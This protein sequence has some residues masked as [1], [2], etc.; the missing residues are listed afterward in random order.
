MRKLFKI[1]VVIITFQLL[2]IV[3]NHNT[4]GSELHKNKPQLTSSHFYNF[5]SDYDEFSR[6]ESRFERFLSFWNVTGAS[7]AF[8]KD[9]KLIYAKGFGQSNR[10]DNHPVEPYHLFRIASVSKLVTGTAIMKLVEDGKLNLDDCVFGA[11][12]LLNMAPY[13]AY[14]DKKVEEITVRHL[15]EHS[16]GWTTRYGDPL[17]EQHHLATRYGYAE[18]LSSEDIIA[19]MLKKRL[20]FRPGTASYYSNLG[21]VI[22]G[23]V[24]EKASGMN[25]ELY[26]KSEILHP[27]GIFD[28]TLGKNLRCEKDPLEVNYYEQDDAI[29]IQDCYGNG[30]LV[31]KSDGGN[32]LLAIEAAGAWI[33]SA[34]DILKLL[35]SLDGFDYPADILSK[36]SLT[37]MVTP[38]AN[39]FSPLGWRQTNKYG[40]WLRTGSF[41]G[42]SAV[43][44]RRPDGLA[45]V[46][47]CN[48]SVWIGPDYPFKLSA[49]A[50]RELSRLKTFPDVNLFEKAPDMFLANK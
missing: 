37:E 5:Q 48:T 25:Y 20:H 13:N 27:L 18:P 17:F 15:L 4:Q 38:K 31:S 24:I 7:V 40:N 10:E 21:F 3:S 2:F 22:L 50:D 43:L 11:E 9:G 45:Y 28:M 23:K 19:I 36:E 39:G 44:K 49:F 14:R 26:V 46:I 41:A 34:T 12:G 16:G 1:L 6:F 35:L 29:K 42:S 32:N 47:L 30:N 33:A 8:A